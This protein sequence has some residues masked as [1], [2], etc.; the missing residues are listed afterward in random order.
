M[1]VGDLVMN[2]MPGDGYG[3]FGLVMEE[4]KYESEV[5]TWV[6]YFEDDGNWRWYSFDERYDVEV[7]SESR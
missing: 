7:I 4:E 6:W 2:H 1:K 3:R 5:G